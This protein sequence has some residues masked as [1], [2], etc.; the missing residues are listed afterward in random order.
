MTE[1]AVL[2]S[3]LKI[4]TPI[5]VASSTGTS[6]LHFASVQTP[7]QMYFTDLSVVRNVRIGRGRKIFFP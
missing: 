5:A 4:D 6:I 3:P 2:K 7:F 1:D